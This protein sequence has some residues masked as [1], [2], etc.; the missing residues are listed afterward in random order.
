MILLPHFRHYREG[1]VCQFMNCV[2][3]HNHQT[4]IDQSIT[5]TTTATTIQIFTDQKGHT[6]ACWDC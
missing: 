2:L 6:Q 3:Q 4:T 1:S 5:S